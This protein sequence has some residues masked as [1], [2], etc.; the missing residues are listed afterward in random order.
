MQNIVASTSYKAVLDN[1]LATGPDYDEIKDEP[2]AEKSSEKL[3]EEKSV[4]LTKSNNN[5]FTL[6]PPEDQESTSN[7]FD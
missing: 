5:Y 1:T 6:V 3:Q 2:G 7:V 4:E